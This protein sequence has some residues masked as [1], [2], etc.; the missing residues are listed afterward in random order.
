MIP[1][2]PSFHTLKHASGKIPVM[3]KPASGGI[4]PENDN[5]IDMEEDDQQILEEVETILGEMK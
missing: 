5:K 4:D 2:S 1:I 3:P